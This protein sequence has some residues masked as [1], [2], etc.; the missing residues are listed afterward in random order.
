MDVHATRTNCLTGGHPSAAMLPLDYATDR[1]ALTAAL[2]TIGLT[3]PADARLM[4]I[5]NTLDV[6]EVECSA[7]YLEE[8][9]GRSDL[10]ILC[11]PRPLPLNG[12][13]M[14]P[15]VNEFVAADAAA[16]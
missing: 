6:A 7:A 16:S 3:E 12:E 4:W 9:R 10:T 5:R 11:D 13:G 15:G 2:P 1:E 8:A 14:L